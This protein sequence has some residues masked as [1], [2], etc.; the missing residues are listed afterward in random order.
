MT[1]WVLEE[2]RRLG[3]QVGV[4]APTRESRSRYERLGFV[5]HR[6]VMPMYW[7]PLESM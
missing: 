1:R 4:V 5:L 2:A 7:Y 6:Q 3:A